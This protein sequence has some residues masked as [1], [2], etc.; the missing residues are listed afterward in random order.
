M[1]T[2][3][4]TLIATLAFAGTLSLA[5]LA[6]AANYPL[7]ITQPQP[8]LDTLNR[9][10][11]AYPG[12]AYQVRLSTIGG[13]YPYHYALGTA[14]SGMTIDANTGAISWANP[15]EGGTPHQVQATVTDGEGSTHSVTWTIT[16][17]TQGFRFVDAVNGHSVADGGTG[18]LANPWRTINDWYEGN[19]YA[20]KYA[21]SYVNEFLYW[22]AGVYSLADVYRENV[23]AGVQ[24][25]RLPVNSV[26]K[27]VVWLAYPGEK[28]IIEHAY[29]G[30]AD[31][32]PFIFFYGTSANV[33][34]DGFEFRNMKCKGFEVGADGNNQ[35]FRNLDM[36][37]LQYGEDGNNCAFIMTSTGT[38][39]SN[40]MT[41]QNSSFHDNN[42]ATGGAMI[43]IY[44]KHKL[45]IEDSSLHTVTGPGAADSEGIALKGGTMTRA[46]VRHNVVYDV[47]D[48]M[49]GG[50]QHVLSDSEILF[51]CV[52]GNDTGA[53]LDINQDGLATNLF[54]YRNTVR[55]RVRVQNTTT[56]N[57][58]FRLYD[59][60]FIN[61]DPGTPSGSHVFYDQV[62][63]PSRVV[64][65]NNLTG[66]PADGILDANGN[67][68]ASH[69]SY[70]T[71][72]GCQ[73]A[74]T[75][76]GPMGPNGEPSDGSDGGVSDP[77]DGGAGVGSDPKEGG[78][79][80]GNA[81]ESGCAAG[82]TMPR[83]LLPFGLLFGFVL[84]LLARRRT[85]R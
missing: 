9:F 20:S 47:P 69:Q 64:L 17:T 11:K 4:R 40:Y 41:I 71:T 29:N 36:H 73:G 55:G 16:V 79:A 57:G 12:L 51:N 48:R 61:S 28:P 38:D 67:L 33:Y 35:T 56:P 59:N 66:Y 32:G 63:D 72:H 54:Y 75:F 80:S 78:G 77:P 45:L 6:E 44:A 53:A 76:V 27:P 42:L 43:K 2:L 23:V 70:A 1:Y 82:G 13:A 19:V 46:T 62:S 10:Y 25:G 50:N 14:P 7:E 18:T 84:P 24:P 34:I 30:A 68:S 74:N 60:I 5:T 26:K 39:P 83:G 52:S 31:S 21:G 37:H 65:T 22:R 15:T 3:R 58:P 85:K 8:N 49:I 81:A